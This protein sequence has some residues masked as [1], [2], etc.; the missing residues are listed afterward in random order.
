MPG[1]V[2]ILRLCLL[3]G[4]GFLN[5]AL[6]CY[7]ESCAGKPTDWMSGIRFHIVPIALTPQAPTGQ[8]VPPPAQ[9]P[10]FPSAPIEQ[11]FSCPPA[12]QFQPIGQ[13]SSQGT[14][15]LAQSPPRTSAL[16]AATAQMGQM[17]QMSQMQHTR[18]AGHCNLAR[19]IAAFDRS[20]GFYFTDTKWKEL[21]ER[22][23]LLQGSPHFPFLFHFP[24]SLRFPII[25]HTCPSLSAT[26]LR[27]L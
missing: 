25:H 3:G 8:Q 24:S 17:A 26:L 11:Q 23:F 22:A 27:V 12:G 6:R 1:P 19:Q 5:A 18:S 9:A 15:L 7:L 20:Y 2:P 21:V 10:Q 4:D 13:Q 14:N 16:G